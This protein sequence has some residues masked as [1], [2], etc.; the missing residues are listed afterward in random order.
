VVAVVRISKVDRPESDS[1]HVLIERT[2]NGRF[3]SSGSVADERE[4]GN[5]KTGKM[6]F[7]GPPISTTYDEAERRAVA[8]ASYQGVSTVY[9][10]DEA[11]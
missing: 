4:V 6:T 2:E 10:I 7:Y 9:V 11:P 1:D 8:W 5:P 3:R